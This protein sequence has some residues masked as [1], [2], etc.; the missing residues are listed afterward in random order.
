MTHP[1]I[2]PNIRP[3]GIPDQ[4]WCKV[5]RPACPTHSMFILPSIFLLAVKNARYRPCLTRGSK[6][7]LPIIYRTYTP[8]IPT[9]YR[10]KGV[11]YG[12]PCLSMP[13]ALHPRFCS[14]TADTPEWQAQMSPDAHLDHP[15]VVP[16]QMLFLHMSRIPHARRLAT[17]GPVV[18]I[19][20]ARAW[21]PRYGT[22]RS[23]PGSKDNY[24][25]V[26]DPACPT[27]RAGCSSCRVMCR[28]V[29]VA[30]VAVVSHN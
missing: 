18:R 6:M 21:P 17:S 25:C 19:T 30:S 5:M 20:E 29:C 4:T 23:S 27:L 14:P 3:D 24:T 9:L 13:D 12:Y 2:Y 22:P 15:N 1:T 16:E 26:E 10:I 28:A 8:I 11:S 7:T